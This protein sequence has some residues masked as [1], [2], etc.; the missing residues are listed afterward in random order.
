MQ[1]VH[2]IHPFL[3]LIDS[4][5]ERKTKRRGLW[6]EGGGGW[7]RVVGRG[8]CRTGVGGGGFSL[9]EECLEFAGRLTAGYLRDAGHGEEAVEIKVVP[10]PR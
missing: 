1:Y 9:G 7:K 3:I 10:T 4:L 8:G 5:F 6:W 2:E